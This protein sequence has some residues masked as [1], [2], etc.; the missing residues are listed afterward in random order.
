M[1]YSSVKLYKDMVKALR[2]TKTIRTKVTP[3][4][5]APA[6]GW[7]AADRLTKKA[8]ELYLQSQKE[9]KEKQDISARMRMFRDYNKPQAKFDPSKYGQTPDQLRAA[10]NN[11]AN[12]E[13]TGE[14]FDPDD[15]PI[16]TAEEGADFYNTE[17][18]NTQ[19]RFNKENPYGMDLV[20]SKNYN[21]V[22]TN[23]SLDRFFGMEKDKVEGSQTAKMRMALTMDSIGRRD[24]ETK[25]LRVID[26][27][28]KLRT[29]TLGDAERKHQQA[30]EIKRSPGSPKRGGYASRPSAGIQLLN[31]QNILRDDLEIAE[32]NNDMERA[33]RIKN[34]ISR[35]D[36]IINNSP[37]QRGKVAAAVAGGRGTTERR[38]IDYGLAR[39]A[40]NNIKDI[41]TLTSRLLST[42]DSVVGFL[43]DLRV[44]K[45][46]T[47]AKFG[48]KEA[49][50]KVTDTQMVNT[51]TGKEV[52]PLIKALGIGARGLDTPAERKFLRE[53]LTG[54]KTLTKA[55]LL[56][57]AAMR[58]K[59][60]VRNIERWNKDFKEGSL[61]DFLR[62]NNI[63]NRE[64]TMPPPAPVRTPI[65][66]SGPINTMTGP[67]LNALY[68]SGTA[69]SEQIEQIKIRL[70]KLG[71][72]VTR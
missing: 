69:T 66:I 38:L 40:T 17:A 62:T 58:R 64:F 3:V 14:G 29:Q 67:Q 12:Y 71:F 42:D 53:V 51:L 45:D 23:S 30:L 65:N 7:Q 27:A 35:L 13:I 4:S 28:A 22:D 39:N 16:L 43:V 18:A 33:S 2:P 34:E 11:I 19:S 47:L 6:T 44:L 55:T 49:L 59:V 21:S 32:K 20:N 52:F 63:P 50:A 61:N 26:A 72:K 10:G 68:Q 37:E 31:R 41:D 70:N 54:D 25:R 36:V 57:M 1:G 24:A 8:L 15:E 56:E 48:S 5:S 46:Q 9:E 60:Q